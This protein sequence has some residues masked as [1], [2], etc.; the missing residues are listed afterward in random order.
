MRNSIPNIYYHVNSTPLVFKITNCKVE[1]NEKVL[2][3]VQ[4]IDYYLNDTT[5]IESKI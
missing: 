3:F 5:I 2:S 1:Q 4:N